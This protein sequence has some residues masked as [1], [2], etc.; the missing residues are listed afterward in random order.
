[1]RYYSLINSMSR[2][3][4]VETNLVYYLDFG[5]PSCYSGIGLS[6]NDLVTSDAFTIIPTAIYS[7]AN[8]GVFNQNSGI[9]LGFSANLPSTLLG[10]VDFTVAGWFKLNANYSNGSPWGFGKTNSLNNFNAFSPTLNEISISLNG[11]NAF[12]S[13]QVFSN[14]VWKYVVWTKKAG[15]FSRANCEIYVDNVKYTGGALTNYYGS[16]I[17]IPNVLGDKKI[18]LGA[19]NTDF[20]SQKSDLIFGEFKI[21]DKVLTDVEVDYFYNLGL[22]RYT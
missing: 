11:I 22:T 18:A 4:F 3:G 13:G 7:S 19:P 17:A 15:V 1:M 12:G 5:N 8:G 9:G 16:E 20:A 6:A 21:Y 14:S 10:D 2:G